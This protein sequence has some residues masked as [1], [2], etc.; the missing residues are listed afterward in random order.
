MKLDTSL[1]SRRILPGFIVLLVAIITFSS[2]SKDG[3][4]GDYEVSPNGLCYKVIVDNKQAKAQPGQYISYHVF[5][6]TMKDSLLFSSED[7]KQPLISMV[8]RPIY[9]G[10]LW[11]IFTFLGD[12]D[13]ASARVPARNV[14]KAYLPPGMKADDMMKVD[15][16]V[17]SVLSKEKYDSVMRAKA[18]AALIK[19]DQDLQ[20]Y[21][22]NHNLSATKTP[23]GMYVVME[24]E[25]TGPQAAIGNTL[26][27][28][29]RGTLLNGTEF[30]A[31]MQPG[32]EPYELVLG[33]SPLIQGWVEGLTY[34]KKGGKGKL[35]IPSSLG[36]G[37]RGNPPKIGP[38]EPLIFDIVMVDIK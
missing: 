33:S 1:S 34:F 27:V 30:D 10:D 3:C 38:N 22:R 32:R 25:G 18:N 5:W 16:K 24:K 4:P 7:A 12:G 21:A 15:L 37:E 31:S 23:S 36:Y 28:D 19:E 9:T 20:D 13:S 11:E 14:F 8:A 2:C 29:Y 35:L 17:I 6:R 26:K